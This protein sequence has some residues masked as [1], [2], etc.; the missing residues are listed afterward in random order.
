MKNKKYLGIILVISAIVG[1]SGIVTADSRKITDQ[2]ELTLDNAP[3]ELEN[4]LN[5][6]EKK[7]TYDTTFPEG[8]KLYENKSGDLYFFG[9]DGKITEYV[10]NTDTITFEQTKINETDLLKAADKYLE[11]LVEDPSYYQLNLVDYDEYTYTHGVA[12][13]HKVGEYNTTDLVYLRID[14]EL[15]LIH[16]SIPRPYA[17]QGIEQLNKDPDNI[18][19]EALEQFRQKYGDELIDAKATNLQLGIDD[20][21]NIA[22]QVDIENTLMMEDNEIEELNI[23]YIPY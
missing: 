5:T 2:V 17:F 18:K 11:N 22:Y 12:Y 15:N 6:D 14:N 16:F 23:E 8:E 9:D 4:I 10:S 7:L 19:Q 1:I 21:G 20:N 13:T 3:K